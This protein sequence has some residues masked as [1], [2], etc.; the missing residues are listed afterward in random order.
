MSVISPR[1]TR[2]ES[3]EMQWPL[4]VTGTADVCR[5]VAGLAA[6]LCLV[7]GFSH[8]S[9]GRPGEDFEKIAPALWVFS[10]GTWC[11]ASRLRWVCVLEQT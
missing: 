3:D 8:G 9:V 2:R 5:L 11:S 1:L 4:G 7:F 6:A 10:L